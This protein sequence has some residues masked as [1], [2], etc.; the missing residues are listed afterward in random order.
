VNTSRRAYLKWCTLCAAFCASSSVV[1]QAVVREPSFTNPT[2]D[3]ARQLAERAVQA[4]K[5]IEG[6]TLDYSPE[7]LK[8][9]DRIVL[10]LRNGG[11]PMKQ[12]GGTLVAFGCYVGEVLV[13]NLSAHWDYP[14]EKERAVGFDILGV[15]MK[16]GG[17]WHPIGKVFKLMAN[18]DE[19]S[20]VY[21]YA[22]VK[23]R[24][25]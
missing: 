3:D 24:E 15:R 18:G 25:P 12:I 1:S 5:N 22:V 10:Q 21:L 16:K 19:D 14:N 11:V 9:I 20:V 17:F 2:P 7:S 23:S 6:I 13:R 8:H 4:A